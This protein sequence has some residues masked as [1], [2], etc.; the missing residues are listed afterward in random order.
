MVSASISFQLVC[1]TWIVTKESEFYME[2]VASQ[3]IY[4]SI[5]SQLEYNY[6]TKDWILVK[7]PFKEFQNDIPMYFSSRY[8]ASNFIYDQMIKENLTMPK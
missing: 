8:E 5:M 6:S 2:M 4:T 7:N 3:S 1:I